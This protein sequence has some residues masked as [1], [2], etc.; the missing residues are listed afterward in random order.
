MP[1][2]AARDAIKALWTA[3]WPA[4]SGVPVHWHENLEVIVPDIASTT[5]WLHLMVEFDAESLRAFGGGAL[6]NDR[7]LFGSTTIRVFTARG[8]GEDTA[9]EYLAD[10]VACFRSRRSADGRLSFIG[11]SSYRVPQAAMEGLWWVRSAL[12]SFEYRY[13]G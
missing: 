13:V 9:L 2:A 3:H 12:V 6:Q 5:H 8:I 10:A 11:E 4:P 1:Y 7:A